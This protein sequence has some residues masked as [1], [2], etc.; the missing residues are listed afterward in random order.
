MSKY[1]YQPALGNLIRAMKTSAASSNKTLYEF[2]KLRRMLHRMKVRERKLRL[3]H[4]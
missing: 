1:T 2:N 3:K 4:K